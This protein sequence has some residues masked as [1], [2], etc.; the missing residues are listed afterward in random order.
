MSPNR[1]AWGPGEWTTTLSLCV[2]FPPMGL[3]ALLR[4]ALGLRVWQ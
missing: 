4:W 1:E 3:A 2:I